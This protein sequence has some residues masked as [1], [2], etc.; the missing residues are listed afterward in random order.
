MAVCPRC[1]GEIPEG[2]GSVCPTCGFVVRIPGIVKLGLTFLVAGFAVAIIWTIQADA[3]FAG[4]WGLLDRLVAQPLGFRPPPFE[5]TGLLK[6]LY[7]LLFGTETQPPWGGVLLIAAGV[8][9]GFAG[10]VILRRA[11]GRPAGA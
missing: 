4:L 7:D 6:T 3:L 2:Y 8:G 5:L 10:G 9:L 11:E 1:A